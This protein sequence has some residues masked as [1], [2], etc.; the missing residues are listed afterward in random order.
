LNSGKAKLYNIID[1]AGTKYIIYYKEK[2]YLMKR[3]THEEVQSRIDEAHGKNKY[4]LLEEY[5]NRRTKILTKHTKCGFVWKTN[6][7]TLADGHGCPKCGKNLKK[8]TEDFKLEVKKLVGNEYIV[9]SEY[10]TNNKLITFKHI[11]CG[12]IFKMSPK[13]F[14]NGQRCPRERYQKSSKSNSMTIVEAREKIRIATKGEY[15]IVGGYKSASKKA[16]IKH[17]PCGNVFEASPT[18]IITI[19]SGCPKCNESHGEKIVSHFL[20]ENNINYKSQYRIK[21]CRNKRP[22]PFDFAIFEDDKLKLLI[23][24]DGEQHFKPKFGKKEFERVKINDSIKN[25]YC[26]N[27]NIDLLR[28]PYKRGNSKVTKERIYEILYNKL[29][30]S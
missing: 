19:E 14:L 9:L 27:N 1:N 29:I 12:N 3:L 6:P 2:H 30:P 16:S 20:N 25:E 22:L 26:K 4:I 28:I 10:K 15:E 13:A 8:T 18:R 17:L 11:T 7:E 5:K 24:Y 21:E 23:E